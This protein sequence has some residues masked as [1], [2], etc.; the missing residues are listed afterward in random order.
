M[1][2]EIAYEY[3]T[4]CAGKGGSG[5]EESDAIMLFVSL[6]PHAHIKHDS[7]KETT[8][9]DAE[10]ETDGK[11]STEVLG[12]TH[13]GANDT[14]YEGESWKP[15]SRGGDFEDDVTR[16]LEQDVTNEVDGQRGEVLVPT[17]FETVV[18]D[19]CVPRA[20]GRENLL[21]CRSVTRPSIRAFPTG[22]G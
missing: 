15:E 9:R 10:E 17:L 4:E 11:E 13:E 12:D 22:R 7:G 19:E 16:D 18:R 5:E 20:G 6:V 2:R 8:F 21:M 3:S 14:P 1:K